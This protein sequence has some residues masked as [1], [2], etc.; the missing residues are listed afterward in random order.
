MFFS[1]V[2]LLNCKRKKYAVSLECCEPPFKNESILQKQIAL[3]VLYCDR[4]LFW[5]HESKFRMRLIIHKLP[6]NS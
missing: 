4:H 6:P 5:I 1:T 3:T 2:G